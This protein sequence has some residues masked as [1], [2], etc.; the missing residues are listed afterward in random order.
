MRWLDSITYSMDL[1]LS[2]FWEVVEDRG[3]LHATVL[4]VSKNPTGLGDRRATTTT[5]A[6]KRVVTTHLSLYH[7]YIFLQVSRTF[8]INLEY[9][10]SLQLKY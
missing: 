6:H 7:H 5:F 10:G 3:G 9:K 2:K 4:G 1:N 8:V